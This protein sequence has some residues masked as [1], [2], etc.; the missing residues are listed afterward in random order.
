MAPLLEDSKN[1]HFCVKGPNKDI[2]LNRVIKE[3]LNLRFQKLFP[4]PNYVDFGIHT[5][6]FIE[7]LGTATFL[8]FVVCLSGNV[9]HWWGTLY[10]KNI[11]KDFSDRELSMGFWQCFDKTLKL[12]KKDKWAVQSTFETSSIIS[13]TNLEI[14]KIL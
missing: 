7:F 12:K 4:V 9:L 10:W 13:C 1:A 14:K 5:P 11:I 3:K 6:E 8:I 2:C